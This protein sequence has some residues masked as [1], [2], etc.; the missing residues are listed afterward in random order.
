MLV[1]GSKEGRQPDPSLAVLTEIRPL[2]APKPWKRPGEV[3]PSSSHRA[4]VARVPSTQHT[5]HSL[6]FPLPERGS[7]AQGTGGNSK[8]PKQR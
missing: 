3:S 8:G 6:H 4:S 2:L 5:V 7:V 1:I